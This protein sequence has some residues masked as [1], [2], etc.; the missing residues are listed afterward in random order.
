M[1]QRWQ[2]RELWDG[3]RIDGASNTVTATVNTQGFV[4]FG[5]AVNVVTNKIYAVNACGTSSG[6]DTGTV[7]I[8]DGATNLTSSVNVQ[9]F[10][11]FAE[12]DL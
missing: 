10:P 3:E 2:L 11:F 9:S 8:I 7:T 12:V 6:C 4:P 1:R 5:I